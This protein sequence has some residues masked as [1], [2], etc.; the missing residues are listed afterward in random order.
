MK[1]HDE[2][3]HELRFMRNVFR[4]LGLA[5]I[6]SSM[7][8]TARRLVET[9]ESRS[10]GS[11]DDRQASS[12][13]WYV[14]FLTLPCFRDDLVMETVGER[15]KSILTNS[16]PLFARKALK[17]VCEELITATGD[18][19]EYVD[20]LVEKLASSCLVWKDPSSS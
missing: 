18:F 13:L 20:S 12:S 15:L 2:R 17:I 11:A 7:N 3:V 10:L 14:V 16:R 19:I 5:V 4:S 6:L 1:D 8:N 9:G